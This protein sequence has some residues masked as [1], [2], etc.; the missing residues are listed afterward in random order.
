MLPKSWTSSPSSTRKTPRIGNG[1]GTTSILEK[2]VH[3]D[4]MPRRSLQEKLCKILMRPLRFSKI[5]FDLPIWMTL[6]NVKTSMNFPKKS[7]KKSSKKAEKHYTISKSIQTFLTTSF[8]QSSNDKKKMESFQKS[9]YFTLP[10]ERSQNH[11]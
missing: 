4:T 2:S 3:H 11:I 10:K 6:L 8:F 1:F 5:F 7:L 9:F